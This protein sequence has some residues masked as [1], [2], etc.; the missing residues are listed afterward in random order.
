MLTALLF[1]FDGLIMDTES[2]EVAIWQE[3]YAGYGV[4]FP[5]GTWIQKVVGSSDAAFDP[6]AHLA[7]LTGADFDPPTL[8]QSAR[9]LR[10]ERQALL[11][12]LPGVS[13]LLSA[14]RTR[15]MQLAIVSSSPHWWV[16]GYLR[17]LD[18]TAFFS[19]VICREDA[20]RV[21]PA[22]DLYL[23][24]LESLH[25]PAQ[26]CLA[27]EDSPNG[28]LAAQRAGLKVVGVPNPITS[29]AG[30]LPAD[31]VLAAL[32]SVSLEELLEHFDR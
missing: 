20:E 18:L 23:K 31:L 8:R 25:L 12:A 11:P 26:A 27:F 7:S 10:L 14:A 15:G 4:E 16:D 9:D 22:P 17:Q 5:L 24:A 3:I 13:E 32:S 30:R 28:V 21:K 2:V 19:P 29:H 6:A 1:D